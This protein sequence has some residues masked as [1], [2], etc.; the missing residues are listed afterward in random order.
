VKYS[1]TNNISQF[2]LM[3]NDSDWQKLDDYCASKN[4]VVLVKLHP[5]Q[6][7]YDIK[8]DKFRNVKI[9]SNEDF[10]RVGIQMYSFLA[11]TTRLCTAFAIIRYP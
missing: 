5:M 7:A 1:D 6:K 4:V 9:I 3:A 11:V 2:P 8:W 10:N